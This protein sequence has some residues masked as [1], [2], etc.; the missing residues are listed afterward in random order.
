MKYARV[1]PVCKSRKVTNPVSGHS[2]TEFEEPE[3]FAVHGI[4]GH[5]STH[6]TEEKAEQV[7]QEWEEFYQK[8]F[9]GKP[10]HEVYK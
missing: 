7:A 8:Q 1:V 9:N 3:R 4:C 10:L 6:L 2:W 5:I